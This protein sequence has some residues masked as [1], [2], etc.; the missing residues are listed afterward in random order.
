MSSL[1]S[2]GCYG[3]IWKKKHVNYIIL[4]ARN[5]LSEVFVWGFPIP[6][7]VSPKK[8]M[9]LSKS[10]WGF[11][12]FTWEKSKTS[13]GFEKPHEFWGL[14]LI[15]GFFP[16]EDFG[17]SN[18][19]QWLCQW[20]FDAIFQTFSIERISLIIYSFYILFALRFDAYDFNHRANVNFFIPYQNGLNELHISW[21]W[22]Q[23][24]SPNFFYAWLKMLNFNF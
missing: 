5:D 8:L 14:F 21:I 24:T 16:H 23:S 11:V 9:P 20:D 1:N 6:H 7:E 12:K 17:L 22:A 18:F 15:W 10:S 3:H 2:L 13:W 19:A 4:P